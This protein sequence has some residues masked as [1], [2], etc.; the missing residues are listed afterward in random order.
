MHLGSALQLN[1]HIGCVMP[2]VAG[3]SYQRPRYTGTLCPWGFHRYNC[4]NTHIIG[5][6][7]KF[8]AACMV[9]YAQGLSVAVGTKAALATASF[10]PVLEVPGCARGFVA[11]CS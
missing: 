9:A 2:V 5:N 1:R 7:D 10:W 8:R 11:E 6:R 3:S 4:C